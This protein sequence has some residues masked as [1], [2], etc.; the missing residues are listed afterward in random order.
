MTVHVALRH[1]QDLS[2]ATAIHQVDNNHTHCKDG[3]FGHAAT[4]HP[5]NTSYL[6][7]KVGIHVAL[8][9]IQT[10]RPKNNEDQSFEQKE[11]GKECQATGVHGGDGDVKVK[12]LP[13]ATTRKTKPLA[14]ASRRQ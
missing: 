8:R 6:L 1:V 13:L 5:R 2:T 4:L 11:D 14:S 3:T 9:H 7:A 10:T 12:P